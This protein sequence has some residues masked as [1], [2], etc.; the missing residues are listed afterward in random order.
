MIAMTIDGRRPRRAAT[1]ERPDIL[2]SRAAVLPRVVQVPLRRK[3]RIVDRALADLGEEVRRGVGHDVVG[4]D[5]PVG[6]V[7]RAR[8]R[9][10]DDGTTICRAGSNS[11]RPAMTQAEPVEQ[12]APR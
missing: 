2:Q 4:F 1:R 11:L 3:L 8:R 6:E 9:R 5:E 10:T 12:F 7:E